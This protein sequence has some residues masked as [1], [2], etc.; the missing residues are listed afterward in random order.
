MKKCI[1]LFL[2]FLFSS[3]SCAHAYSASSIKRELSSIERDIRNDQ[4]KINSIK[5]SSYISDYEKQRKIK[6]LE[7]EIYYKRSKAKKMKR[8][9]SRAIS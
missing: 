7:R 6:K 3:L 1:V 9:Y 5:H 8:E 4:R 2:L